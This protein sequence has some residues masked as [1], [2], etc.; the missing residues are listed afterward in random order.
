MAI[1]KNSRCKY[2]E[3]RT[4]AYTCLYCDITNYVVWDNHEPKYCPLDH[5]E[6]HKKK[7]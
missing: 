7:K 4:E 3:H 2:C 1:D 6:N 5:P